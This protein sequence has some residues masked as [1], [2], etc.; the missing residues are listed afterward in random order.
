MSMSLFGYRYGDNAMTKLS[1]Q[2]FTLDTLLG[3]NYTCKLLSVLCCGENPNIPTLVLYYAR[4]H[5]HAHEVW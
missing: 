5:M 4:A 2:P 3:V 1:L